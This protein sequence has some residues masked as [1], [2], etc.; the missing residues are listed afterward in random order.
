MT[1]DDLCRQLVITFEPYVKSP[2]NHGFLDLKGFH[3]AV[4]AEMQGIK[5]N[6]AE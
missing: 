4:N 5:K 1:E 3:R 6:E 2:D